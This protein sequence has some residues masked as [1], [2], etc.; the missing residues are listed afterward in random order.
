VSLTG[1]Q[2]QARNVALYPWLKFFQNLIFWQAVWFLYFQNELSAAEALLLYAVY[3]VGTMVLEVPSGYMSD[4]LGRR[5]TLILAMLAGG[6][7]A[8]LIALGDTFGIFALAQFLLGTSAAFASGTDNALLFESLASEG[9]E[10]EIEAEE[11][12]G[13]QFSLAGLGLS[14][15]TGGAMAQYSFEL[16]FAASAVSLAVALLIAVRLQEPEHRRETAPRV[17]DAGQ[18]AM[19]RGALRQGVLLWL[20][21]LS[22]LMYGFSHVPFI[23]GQPFIAEALKVF[24]W[25]EGAPVVSGLVTLIM[26]I[27][28]VG[29][30][31]VAL[32]LR[33]RIGLP[34]MLLLAFGIQ[35]A[36]IA[37]LAATNNALAIAVL[38][39]RMVP[40]SFA[41]PFI[42]ARIQPL[43]SDGARATYLSIQSFAGRLLFAASLYLAAGWA[44]RSGTMS[45]ADIQGTLFWYALTGV[46]FFVILCLTVRRAGI[47]PPRPAK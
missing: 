35:I 10:A 43:L 5:I 9:R 14:A 22:V 13:W 45:Y 32:R 7:G 44:P 6:L 47:E 40:N 20:F 31:L 16:S 26:M 3:D 15:V 4:K 27:V 11:T 24:G 28:S 36:L 46:V 39:L 23:F 33:R 8:G 12:K 42:V 34:A 17:E 21:F 38:F 1:R 37:V 29:A 30:S 25:Q 18:L 19:L 41:R 2:G